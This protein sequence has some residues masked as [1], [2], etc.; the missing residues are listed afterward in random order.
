MGNTHGSPIYKE[1][2]GWA[3]STR[4]RNDHMGQ[5]RALTATMSR[6]TSL[7]TQARTICRDFL[8][9]NVDTVSTIRRVS[10]TE[11]AI[12]GSEEWG[13]EALG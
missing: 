7:T 11:R 13:D 10:L 12:P 3:M 5:P 9:S 6:W 2:K 1:P 8:T 4:V